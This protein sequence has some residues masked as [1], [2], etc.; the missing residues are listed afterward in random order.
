MQPCDALDWV[1]KQ[2]LKKM[3]VL[4]CVLQSGQIGNPGWAGTLKEADYVRCIIGMGMVIIIRITLRMF[5]TIRL[6]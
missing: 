5:F 3:R 1:R 2:S 4:N 6:K